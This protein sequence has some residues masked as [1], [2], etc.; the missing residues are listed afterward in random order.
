MERDVCAFIASCETPWSWPHGLLHLLPIPA[1]PWSHVSLDFVTGLPP[2]KRNTANLV[3]VDRFSKAC[4]FVALPKLPSA[5]ET[6]EL[7][8]QHVVR[9]HGMPSDLVFDRGPQLTSRLWK[10]F[11][12]LMGASEE[13][14]VGV[15]AA[16]QFI[17]C[18]RRAW[19]KARASLLTTT[20][21]RKQVADR[22]RHPVPTFRPGQRVWLSAREL[23]LY[24]ESKKLAPNPVVSNKPSCSSK[25]VHWECMAACMCWAKLGGDRAALAL[26]RA[27]G[28]LEAGTP[29]ASS[30]CL[31]AFIAFIP[32]QCWALSQHSQPLYY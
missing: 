6:V 9:V 25:H 8:L 28:L 1:R 12:Q 13:H 16:E 24:V 23:P 26:G 22:R 15:S 21:A 18:C 5:K 7:L 32:E 27:L 14:E 11:C 20:E 31:S 4:K 10:A 17:Q 29:S 2:S 3:P 30:R 19:Q